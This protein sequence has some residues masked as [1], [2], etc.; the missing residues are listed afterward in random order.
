MVKSLIEK[1]IQRGKKLVRGKQESIISAA[2]IM[3]VL[4]ALTKV[5]GFIKLHLFARYF[6]ASR[7]LDI[8]WAAFTIPDI[9]FSV[10]VGG[11]LNAALIPSFAEKLVGKNS[12]EKASKAMATLFSRILNLF[13]VFFAV[14]C[15]AIYI[16][17]PQLADFM[18]STGQNYFDFGDVTLGGQDIELL[19][20][21]MRIMVWSPFLLAISSVFTAGIQS[22]KRFLVPAIAPLF[23]N[24]GIILGALIPVNMLGMG[25]EG[26]ALGVIAG[27]ALH[28]LVQVPLGW[29]LGLR[30]RP[31]IKFWSKNVWNVVRLALPRVF[32]LIGEQVNVFVNTII[33]M[34]L[35]DG[36]LSAFR[37]G[38]S[39]YILPVHLLSG[40]ISQAA[41]PTLSLEYQQAQKT[42]DWSTF[43]SIFMKSLHQILFFILPSVVFVMVLRLPIVR[44]ALGAGE[45]D[46]WD[47]VVTSWVLA[48]FSLSILG[49]ALIALIMRTF[50]AM[51][52]SFVPV[53]VSF[54]GLF[55]NLAGSYYFTNFFS[56]YYDWRPILETLLERPEGLTAE[57]W[58]DL[59]RWFTTRNSSD[60]AVGGLALSLGVTLIVE[61]I[62]LLIVLNRKLKILNWREFFQPVLRK[63]FASFVMF[64]VMY[65]VY[66]FWNFNLDTSTVVS[67][68]G[69]FS[70][71][72]GLGMITYFGVAAVIDINEINFFLSLAKRLYRKIKE[73][74]ASGN[75]MLG[76]GKIINGSNNGK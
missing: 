49:Q 51:H 21:L 42:G 17:A 29:R 4:I 40:T 24:V 71:V 58:H 8:F 5:A 64:W 65:S 55:V 30:I 7:E 12:G 59:G 45:F 63:L 41:L 15:V 11:S 43:K 28:L 66:K 20:R 25:S 33:S 50:F 36:A 48:L 76:F 23:Y 1:G 31:F 14:S 26:L 46:W 6:G 74:F 16:F 10:I 52:K 67:I 27:S 68:F 35:A 18:I 54:V 60:A 2:F 69:L 22:N 53:L 38:S 9:I 75:K 72:G 62:I 34:N 47:T 13:V 19:T 56:H 73:I 61:I 39:L 70:V 44:L 32:G 3:M 37:F 57:F